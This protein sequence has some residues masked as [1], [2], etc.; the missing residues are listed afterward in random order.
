MKKAILLI[1]LI[2]CF[3]TAHPQNISTLNDLVDETKY[4]L[5]ELQQDFR[6]FRGAFEEIHPGLYWYKSKQETDQGFNEVYASLSDDM[7]MLDFY[8]LLAPIVSEMGCGH[9]SVWPSDSIYKNIY[10]QGL[11]FP[12][13]LK[14]IDEKAYCLQNN[15]QNPLSI[16]PGNEI[17]SIN[18]YP[19]DSMIKQFF[20]YLPHDGFNT[21]FKSRTLDDEFSFYHHVLL[22]ESKDFNI[23]YID[24]HGIEKATSVKAL[25]NKEIHSNSKN[26][27]QTGNKLGNISIKFLDQPQVAILTIKN[28][29]SWR[30]GKKILKFNKVLKNCFTK[31]DSSGTDNLIIDV[32][33][34]LGGRD[35]MGLDLFSYLYEN[36]VREFIKIES[37][38]P[39][40]QHSKYSNHAKLYYF[41]NKKVNDSTYHAYGLKTLKPYGPSKPSYKGQVYIL[42]NGYSFS[43][44]ADFSAMMRSHGRGIFIGEETGGGYYGNTSGSAMKLILPNTKIVTW[45]PLGRYTP[46]VKAIGKVG[47]GIMPDY[48]VVPSIQDLASGTDAEMEFTLDLIAGKKD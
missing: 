48:E 30:N 46:N 39:E 28:F 9:S 38:N 23:T 40:Y 45:I 29:S 43:T 34:N 37:R 16:L 11:F 41:K 21:T 47:R 33:N 42:I 14:F 35:E 18:H 32:R 8:K 2:I 22:G 31:I 1:I 7:S 27:N 4:T 13:K 19:L 24:S 17:L 44:T 12:I 15:S 36:P 20:R 10:E 25:T 6:V 26:K 5:K 3:R